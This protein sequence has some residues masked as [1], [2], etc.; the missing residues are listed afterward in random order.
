MEKIN[1][2]AKV[3]AEMMANDFFSQW[4]GI[5]VETVSAGFCRISL[6]IRK[7]MLNGFGIAHGG[8]AFSLADS[9]LAFASNSH[10]RK[11]LVLDASMSFTAPAKEGDTLTA[12]A[13]EVNLTNRTGIYYVTVT[14]QENKKIA[15]F[16]GIV[17]RKADQW[18]P[19][20]E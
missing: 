19:E 5:N 17:F 9:A 2:P 1:T 8:I 14:N 15:V 3:V 12:I 7:D 10:N 20:S 4:L 6:T 13:E 16:K 11:S 18:F